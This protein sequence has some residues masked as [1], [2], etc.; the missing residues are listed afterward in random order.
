MGQG[1]GGSGGPV[2]TAGAGTNGGMGGSCPGVKGQNSPAGTV[3]TP[4]PTALATTEIYEPGGGGGGGFGA[5]A[6]P[7]NGATGGFPGGGGGGGG[8]VWFGTGHTSGSGGNGG[9]GMAYIIEYF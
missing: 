6:S 7:G 1:G 3:A 4:T 2:Q 8:A 9:N 5:T